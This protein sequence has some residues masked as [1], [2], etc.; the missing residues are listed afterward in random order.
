MPTRRSLATTLFISMLLP[1]I[2]AAQLAD[3]PLF[4][5]AR[6]PLAPLI[7]SSRSG[8]FLV[9]EIHATN[10]EGKPITWTS[11]DVIDGE[12]GA[13]ITTVRDSVLARD[14]ARPGAGNLPPATRATVAPGMRAILYLQVPINKASAPKSLRHRLTFTDSV[15]TRTLDAASTTV[16]GDVAV[17][18]PPL[19]GGVWF[20]ANGP[21]NS[22]GHRL[23]FIPLE[24]RPRIP[25]RF[26]IDYVM[27]D[28]A[29]ATHKGDALDNKN[30]YAND[31]DVLAVADGIVVAVKDGLPE[32]VPGE[33]SRAVPITLETVGGNHIIL[34]IGKGR[35]AFY[36][37]VRPGTLRVKM[38]D[39]VKRGAVLA[40]LGNT[41]NS[42]EPHLHFHIADA[43]SPLGSEGLPYVHESIEFDGKCVGFGTGC[44]WTKPAVTRLV[45]P[46]DGDLV[47]FPK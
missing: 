38:G 4:L 30:Y 26:A 28:T 24:G 45:M 47:R 34:D 15:G 13:T 43:N 21:G 10:M 6:V 36:A 17:I 3:R 20:A 31:V 44:E 2:A 33:Q 16:G 14:L 32:N 35:Y 40:K 12:T 8:A 1:A 25:Q 46:F 23:T 27:I 39:K 19:R 42:T 5:E 7:A 11:V 29:F 18:G 22:S 9:Y 37:H 41:G